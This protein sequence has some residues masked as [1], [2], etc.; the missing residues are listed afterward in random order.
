MLNR[1]CFQTF[2]AKACGLRSEHLESL[3]SHPEPALDVPPVS[4]NT[5]KGKTHKMFQAHHGDL[6]RVELLAAQSAQNLGNA[7]AERS[8]IRTAN[9]PGF[10]FPRESDKIPIRLSDLPIQGVAIEM[11]DH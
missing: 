1:H 5:E 9:H 6:K 10:V 2:P 3:R 7:L 4:R 11:L 8:G